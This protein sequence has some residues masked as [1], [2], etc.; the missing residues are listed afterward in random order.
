MFTTL[1]VRDLILFVISILSIIGLL[2]YIPFAEA[3]IPAHLGLSIEQDDSELSIND[4]KKLDLFDF[5]FIDLG[6]D[7]FT[8]FYSVIED[9]TKYEIKEK[10]EI[11][12]LT[13][14][15]I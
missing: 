13:E 4:D 15:G 2:I 7:F 5:S 8:F 11:E 9:G 1:R 14:R 12:Y 3:E 6:T 10:H